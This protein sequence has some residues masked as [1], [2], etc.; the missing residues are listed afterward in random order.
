VPTDAW[1]DL[2]RR[3]AAVAGGVPWKPGM[4]GTMGW[5]RFIVVAPAE[6]DLGPLLW[7][8]QGELPAWAGH[9]A[10]HGPMQPD[11][12]HASTRGILRAALGSPSM[13]LDRITDNHH[14]CEIL[15][16]TGEWQLAWGE[17]ATPEHAE[18]A[19]LVE[20]AEARTEW[21]PR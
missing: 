12:E 7:L 13:R 10:D 14:S 16:E 4:H 15:D 21:G 1:A 3:A 11:L 20:L 19:A 17:G 8:S 2:N 9:I 6:D 18:A 5:R